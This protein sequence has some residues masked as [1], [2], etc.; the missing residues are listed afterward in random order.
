MQVSRWRGRTKSRRSS[1]R[2]ASCHL[3][4]TTCAQTGSR[5]LLTSVTSGDSYRNTHACSPS[6]CPSS[7]HYL[8]GCLQT[9]LHVDRCLPRAAGCRGLQSNKLLPRASYSNWMLSPE[10]VTQEQILRVDVSFRKTQAKSIWQLTS[11]AILVCLCQRQVRTARN[12]R[13]NCLY[14]ATTAS[15]CQEPSVTSSS[16]SWWALFSAKL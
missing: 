4:A 14:F 8:H 13:S 10:G 9:A 16:A 11:C 5:L 15:G 7:T 1:P 3:G 6:R 12:G 2:G